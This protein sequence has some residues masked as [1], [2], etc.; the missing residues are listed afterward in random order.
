MCI[1]HTMLAQ[2]SLSPNFILPSGGNFSHS[3]Q[4]K[5]SCLNNLPRFRTKHKTNARI[6]VLS[7]TGE[8]DFGFL[9]WVRCKRKEAYY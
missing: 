2:F 4:N 1:K 3:F 7:L 8:L 9:E 5:S 6:P